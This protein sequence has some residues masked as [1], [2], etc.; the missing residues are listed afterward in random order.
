MGLFDTLV[1][2]ATS[3]MS[4]GNQAGEQNQALDMVMDLINQNGGNVGGLLQQLQQGGLG[5]ALQSW[6]STDENA[7]VSAGDIENALGG[8]LEQLATKFGLD[9]QQASGLLAQYLPK[10]IDMITP[11]GSAADA[12]GFGMDDIARIAMEKFLK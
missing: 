11:N 8:G 7:E 5:D 9:S 3:A 1:K 4:G 12:D 2:V 6:I 10:V